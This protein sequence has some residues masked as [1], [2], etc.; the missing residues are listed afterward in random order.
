MNNGEYPNRPESPLVTIAD[1]VKPYEHEDGSSAGN[2]RRGLRERLSYY[3]ATRILLSLVTL[4]G[5]GYLATTQVQNAIASSVAVKSEFFAPYVDT[6]LTPAYQF[7]ITNQNMAKQTVLGFITAPPSG[8]CSPSWGG[9]YSLNGAESQLNLTRRLVEYQSLGGASMISFGGQ[10]GRHLSTVCPT[11]ASLESA[12]SKVI[13]AYHVPAIDLDTEGGAL[14]NFA[15]MNRRALALR[16][17]ETKYPKLQVWLTLPVASNGLQGN[18]LGVVRTMLTHKVRLTGINV[19]TMDFGS[20]S[21]N[22]ATTVEGAL[23]ATQAQLATEFHRH[24]IHLNTKQIYNRMGATVEIGQN[25]SYG[26]VF[27]TS[28][29]QSLAAFAL[30]TSLRRVSLWSLNRDTPCTSTFGNQEI[31]ST[32]CSGT[33]QSNLQ[34]SNIFSHA[35]NGS[36]T[37]HRAVIQAPTDISTNPANAPYPIWQPNFPYPEHYKVVWNGYVYQAKYYN[38]GSQPTQTYQYSYQTPWLLV[39]PVLKTDHAPVIPKLKP[40]TY[41]TWNSKQAYNTGTDVELGGYGYQ[42]KYYTQGDNPASAQSNPN[43]SPWKPLFNLPGEPPLN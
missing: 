35:L 22:M 43:T 15:A 40:G 29:A 5:I 17:L 14:N 26:E 7:Q 9:Y 27:T 4:S 8:S 13:A 30:R 12:Y 39:G 21:A 25:N 28:D 19:M 6:T 38:Q 16:L 3:S 36:I 32:T 20:P 11:P 23:R 2:A 24:G 10:R 1:L 33:P 41:P 42:A 18:A 31:Y 37:S 34:F